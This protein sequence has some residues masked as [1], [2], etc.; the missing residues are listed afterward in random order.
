MYANCRGIKGKKDSFN[1]IVEKINP[2]IIVLNETMY[3][4][5]ERSRPK[6][7]KS[8][9]KNREGKSGGGIEILV[10]NSIENR[11]IIISEGTPEIEEL[12]IRTESKKRT[13]NVISLYGKKK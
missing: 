13:L 10:R 5:N 8:Y 3:Q 2:D 11:T 9:T 1:E 4:N 12:T 6:A 7:Y